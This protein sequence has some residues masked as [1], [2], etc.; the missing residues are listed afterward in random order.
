MSRKVAEFETLIG[1]LERIVVSGARKIAEDQSS[2]ESPVSHGTCDSL[3]SEMLPG[4]VE[5]ATTAPGDELTKIGVHI[6]DG[7]PEGHPNPPI[8][9]HEKNLVSPS[10]KIAALNQDPFYLILQE[11]QGESGT[12]AAAS[13]KSAAPIGQTSH[14]ISE[15]VA[16]SISRK[17]A[18][19]AADQEFGRRLAENSVEE[20]PMV[21]SR[22][23]HRKVAELSNCGYSDDQIVDW[24]YREAYVAGSRKA[25]EDMSAIDPEQQAVAELEALVESGEITP[26]EAAE[27]AA[28][29]DASLG[30]EGAEGAEG[31]EGGGQNPGDQ[32]AVILLQMVEAG[33]ISEDDALEA[34]S[35]IDAE[36][37]GSVDPGEDVEQVAA[38]ALASMVES[39]ELTIEEAEEAAN[40]IDASLSGGGGGC[41]VEAEYDD[42]DDYDDDDEDEAEGAD[43]ESRKEA[44]WNFKIASSSSVD[45]IF[46]VMDHLCD[47]GVLTETGAV[48]VLNSAQAGDSRKL[49]AA[50]Q[51]HNSIV[52]LVHISRK[53]AE[54]MYGGA[55]PPAPVPAPAPAPGGAE[56]GAPGGAPGGDPNAAIEQLLGA[57]EQLVAL[58]VVQEDAAVQAVEGMGLISAEGG[59]PAGGAPAP[60]G[61]APP[62]PPAP[63]PMP[64][65]PAPAI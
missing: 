65:A 30:A 39:G 22:E 7:T 52:D 4:G 63:A 18:Q 12:P 47:R 15:N 8:E 56:G 61:G 10:S 53:N 28:E 17:L 23:I 59:A 48:D 54:E 55:M 32:A 6:D 51:V 64:P 27:A 20:V 38:E 1:D 11:I 50:L 45:D 31:V 33:E 24:L 25:A 57:L 29:I 2:Q 35:E 26:E 36:L 3:V 58:G 37:G 60:G 42:D 43:T 14:S 46:S 62:M 9:E 49:A 44:S 5:D 16:D 19:F 13:R 34:A 21:S 41:E 40:E